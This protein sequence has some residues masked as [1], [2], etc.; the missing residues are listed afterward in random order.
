[1]PRQQGLTY[2]WRPIPTGRHAFAAAA[3][4]EAPDSPVTSYCGV[5]TEAGELHGR[6]EREWVQ[7]GTCMEC[8]RALTGSR[9]RP[10]GA[11]E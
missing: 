10:D 11:P 6:T 7:Q 2:V 5:H 9:V 8:W 1:M 3:L 4:D